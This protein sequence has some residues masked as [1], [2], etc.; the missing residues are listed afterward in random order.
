MAD[1]LYERVPEMSN[2]IL[3]SVYVYTSNSVFLI[4]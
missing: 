1:P 2:D 4:D 3:K